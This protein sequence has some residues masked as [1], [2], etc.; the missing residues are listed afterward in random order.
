MAMRFTTVLQDGTPRDQTAAAIRRLI[1]S[2]GLRP[3]DALPIYRELAQQFR[4]SRA[5][6]ERAMDALAE[7]GLVRR[8]H[9]KGTFVAKRISRQSVD[10]TR[11][12]IV[13]TSRAN[14]FIYPYLREIMTGLVTACERADLDLSILSLRDSGAVTRPAAELAGQT[15]AV[16][17]LGDINEAYI[18][19]YASLQVPIVVVDHRM[20]HAPFDCLVCDNQ[21]A[22]RQVVEHLIS[23]GHRQ[24]VFGGSSWAPTSL[25]LQRQ[26]GLSS[27]VPERR[28]AY[29]ET[30]TLH[31][32]SSHARVV[33]TAEAFT[34]MLRARSGK[35]SRQQADL[36]TAVVARSSM[37]APH[38][39]QKLLEIGLR[40]PQDI[41]VAGAVGARDDATWNG[42]VITCSCARF[43][44]MGAAA[45]RQIQQR[46]AGPQPT[47]PNIIRIGSD[48]QLGATTAP[49]PE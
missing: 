46:C 1:L 31:G 18:E 14:L 41:S 4:V 16:L 9:G 28:D 49:P 48:L 24:I 2:R 37:A 43:R 20:N 22:T 12:T 27:D 39:C 25:D 15:D 30:M 7:S 44:E 21:G 19:K 34:E 47:A 35:N 11:L 26:V 17:F 42:Q 38:Y 32:L 33:E 6:V 45:V 13:V 36:P 40:V 8:M 23:L 29:L 3:G 5:T 10:L